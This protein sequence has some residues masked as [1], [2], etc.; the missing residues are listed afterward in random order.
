MVFCR[1]AFLSPPND[2]DDGSHNRDEA[3]QQE[4]TALVDVVQTTGTDAQSGKQDSQRPKD[5]DDHAHFARDEAKDKVDKDGEQEGIPEFFTAGAA[6][7]VDVVLQK[8]VFCYSDKFIHSDKYLVRQLFPMTKVVK[9]T[10]F[11]NDIQIYFQKLM[12][13][14]YSYS[15]FQNTLSE[16]MKMPENLINKMVDFLKILSENNKNK[17]QVIKSFFNHILMI[18]LTQQ[19]TYNIPIDKISS[20]LNNLI[21]S[22]EPNYYLDCYISII[23][24]LFFN[25]KAPKEIKK[26]FEKVVKN[27]EELKMLI[28]NNSFMSLGRKYGVTDNTIRKWCKAENL[29]FKSTEIKQYTDNEWEL[30]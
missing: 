30:I 12:T 4:P 23:I 28:R 15:I 16:K 11:Q 6:F 29:P 1:V 22:K 20:F 24:E 10:S 3:E 17:S 14:L 21:S 19:N 25:Q 27:R 9:K 5:G 26:I 2:E 18:V 7:K 8:Y 13:V